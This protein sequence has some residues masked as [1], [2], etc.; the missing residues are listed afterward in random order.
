MLKKEHN[1]DQSAMLEYTMI[2][3]CLGYPCSTL[4][5]TSIA[6]HEQYFVDHFQDP[7]THALSTAAR[8]SAKLPVALQVVGYPS[9]DERV[10]ALTKL[11]QDNIEYEDLNIEKK[12]DPLK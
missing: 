4:P 1:L 12:L 10:L 2:W 9:E 3:S 7:W 5:V 8:D 6:E 11:L